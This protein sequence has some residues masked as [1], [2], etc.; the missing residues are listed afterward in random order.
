[1][2]V[3]Q[4]S[5][6]LTKASFGVIS[7][8]PKLLIFPFVSSI[9][10]VI[11]FILI[12]IPFGYIVGESDSQVVFYGALFFVYL[13]LYMTVIFFNVGLV[14]QIS[15][16]IN[17]QATSVGAGI[18]AATS[19]LGSIIGYAAIASTVGVLL[20]ILRDQSGKGGSLAGLLGS[21]MA[22]IAGAAWG[23]VTFLVVPVLVFENKGPIAAIRGSFD[24]VKRSWGAQLVGNATIGLI[25]FLLYIPAFIWAAIIVSVM[26]ASVF[27]A[28]GFN[29]VALIGMVV[30]AGLP[31]LFLIVLSAAL[32][33]I[34]RTA[35]YHFAQTGNLTLGFSEQLVKEAFKQKA[36]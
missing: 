15:A 14:S 1:M 27:T 32:D 18:S 24:L 29:A 25:F 35:V 6:S 22:S 28:V 9:A 12:M 17:N 11:V 16:K 7:S 20:S 26:G 36:A 23:V 10:S 8:D 2:N 33:T 5:W 34:Y 21:I 30:L 19:R 31:F 4:R 13:A 3:F